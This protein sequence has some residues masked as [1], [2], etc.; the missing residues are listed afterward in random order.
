MNG[1]LPS[2]GTP[3]GPGGSDCRNLLRYDQMMSDRKT[4]NSVENMK[5][6]G[7]LLSSMD[8]KEKISIL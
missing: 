4:M 5:K 8:K 1:R 3:S 2:K 6:N 7:F